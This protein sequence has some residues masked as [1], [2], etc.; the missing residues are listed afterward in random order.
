MLVKVNLVC[1]PKAARVRGFVARL[2]P[3]RDP[4]NSL[5]FLKAAIPRFSKNGMLVGG[6]FDLEV[7]VPYIIRSDDSSHRNSRQRYDLV[8]LKEDG[9]LETVASI[10]YDN[11]TP[12]FDP[13]ELKYH[14]AQHR[15]PIR[16]LWSYW[17]EKSL[18]K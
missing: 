15:K 9:R 12:S 4:E 8:V 10:F 16:A 18:S 6:E 5:D 17:Q 3:D 11:N 14:Y 2:Y 7:G 1:N 13:P